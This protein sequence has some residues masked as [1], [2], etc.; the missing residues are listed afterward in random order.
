MTASRFSKFE[1][2]ALRLGRVV[3]VEPGTISVVV[4]AYNAVNVLPG[5]LSALQ[6]QTCP[7]NEIIVVDDGSSDR[8]CQVAEECRATVIRQTHQGPAAARN[9][10]IERAHGD[11]ILFTDADCEPMTDWVEQMV[12]PFANPQI[13]GVKGAYRTRQR[14]IIARL[15]Q[16][17]FEE[18]YDLLERNSQIDFVDSYAAAFRAAALRDIG[19]FDPSFPYANNED[20]DLSYR[21]ASRGYKLVFNRQAIVYHHHPVTWLKYLRLKITRGYWRMIVY[22]HHPR[23]ALSDSYTPQVLKIQTLLVYLIIFLLGFT[24]FAPFAVIAAAILFGVLFFS[25][26]PFALKVGRSQSDIVVW[27]FPFVAMRALAFAIGVIGGLFGMVWVGR[28]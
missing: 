13:V 5:C 11:V 21:L 2:P 4:P 8:T 9:L 3:D 24:V 23:K 26:F 19:G 17:E 14:E 15:A 16:C 18:R 12:A 10:G 7:P 1:I 22:L 27:A 28:G 6:H 25:A 20:V